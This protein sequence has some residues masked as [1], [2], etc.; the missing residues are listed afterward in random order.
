MAS[1]QTA[2]VL[3]LNILLPI[4]RRREPTEYINTIVGERALQEIYLK[5]FQI[6]VKE[7]QPWTVMSSV[8]TISMEITL[9]KTMTFLQR[10]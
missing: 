5:G 4:T 9:P 1:N 7:S 6:A 8:A 10:Y 2:W 3:P